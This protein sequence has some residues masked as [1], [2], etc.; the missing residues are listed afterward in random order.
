M[1]RD[2]KQTRRDLI[3]PT[4]MLRGWTADLIRIEKTPGG[5]DIVDGKPIKK[6]GRCD[7]LLCVP[8]R[9]GA[10]PLPVAILEAKKE[11]VYPSLGIE[12][13]MKYCKQF[14][15]PFAFS[16]NG[17]QYIEFAED[18]G[19][20]S[21]ESPL[22]MIPTP[23]DLR[24]RY[25]LLK[26]IKL[27]SV[28][29][30]ALIASYKGG[31]GVRRYYQDAAIRAVLERIADGEKRCL[32]SLAT[33]TGKTVIA[34]LLLHKIASAG[35][36]TR[37]LFLCDRDELRT[38]AMGHMNDVFEDD[39]QIVTTDN[40]HPNARVLIATYQTLNI[41]DDD[42]E[43][44][45]WTNNFP[46]GYFSHIIIDECH[47]SAWSKWS[48]VL[49]DN[50]DAIQIG[51][52]AT[53]RT[54]K[55]SRK[56][57]TICDTDSEI[58]AHN[59]KYFGE[60]VYEYGISQGQNDGYLAACEIVRR[61][62]DIDKR[63][64]TREDIE[65][66]TAVDP[67]TGRLVTPDE[68]DDSYSAERYD[69][70]LVLEDRMNA[71]SQDLFSMLLS[72]GDPHQKTIIFC[73]R[74]YQANQIAIKLQNIYMAWCREQN[75]VPRDYYAFK[76]TAANSG[77]KAKDLIPEFRG[78]TLSH[79]I[80]TTVDLLSTGVDIPNLQNVCF[81]RYIKSP[82]SFYQMVGR[83]T[84]TGTPSGS[85]LMFTIY[86]YTNATRLFGESFISNAK[87]SRMT[88]SDVP[89]KETKIVK[90]L[91]DEFQI[92]I[93]N[94]GKSILCNINGIDTLVP[95]E[96]YKKSV[97]E[98][99]VDKVSTIDELRDNWVI[100]KLRRHLID[101]LPGGEGAVRLIRELENEQ[102]CD[103]FDVLAELGFGCEPKSR[104]ER[105]A[106]FSFRHKSW[107]NQFPIPSQKVLISI[108]NQFSRGGIEELE[109]ESLFDVPEIVDSGGFKSML[110]LQIPPHDL[111]VDVKRRLLL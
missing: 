11:S 13:A 69:N 56:N 110:R 97:S 77:D 1:N 12:Q 83:G 72:Q 68:I 33:G 59:I 104:V 16:T 50:P 45:F 53:P 75:I 95:Y 70:D 9:H 55:G 64:I 111:I 21:N 96:E 67:Y 74:D 71:M 81:F 100:Y 26:H 98:K 60:P 93:E 23:D 10:P 38:N 91:E 103:L 85:K 79:Y 92:H 66:R 29:A 14:H 3:D 43:P 105:S 42:L 6:K 106:G 51:L 78:S 65:N 24:I 4:I 94:E 31:E 28:Q 32:L 22:N 19:I 109:S 58:T 40:P 25:E 62:I 89:K 73:S 80:A 90:I 101:D 2:E 7:Y 108:A 39:A 5:T 17:H 15:V 76:I 52:T 82:I 20:I 107:L 37:A 36:L 87:P 61:S 46:K 8:T 57:G 49:T 47:R 30:D 86:D 35:Q 27:D 84:R 34:K 48:I 54:I 102:E 41:S 18:T 63:T 99:L 44:K 88:T